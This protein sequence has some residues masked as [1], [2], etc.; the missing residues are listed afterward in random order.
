MTI[1]KKE[2]DIQALISMLDEPDDKVFKEIYDK[3]VLFGIEAI[4]ALEKAWENSFDSSIQRR[5]ESIIHQIQFNNT[6]IE[7]YNWLHFGDQNLMYG[8]FILSRFYYPDLDE[9][10]IKKNIEQIKQ[11]AWLELNENL[12]ALEQAKVISHVLFDIYKFKPAKTDEGSHELFFLNHV[13]EAKSCNSL[14]SG[15]L[16]AIIAQR[17]SLP[18]YGVNL[19]E[20]FV[21]TYTDEKNSPLFYINPFYKGA[22]FTQNEIDLFLK[23]LKIPSRKSYYEPCSNADIIYRLINQL[24]HAYEQAGFPTKIKDLHELLKAFD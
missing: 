15:I 23:E 8:Y 4:P 20:H 1:S 12:T 9:D 18:I 6:Y 16:Y 21:L 10:Q 14:S 2:K 24:I 22:I 3:F 17:L 19:P 11:D 7:L 5:I 13:L